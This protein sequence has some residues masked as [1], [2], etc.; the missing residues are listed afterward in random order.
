V[1]L[2]LFA[3]DGSG[4]RSLSKD[5]ERLMAEQNY[6]GDSTKKNDRRPL[7]TIASDRKPLT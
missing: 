4:L 5:G 3:V 2:R 1:S 7:P 6:R